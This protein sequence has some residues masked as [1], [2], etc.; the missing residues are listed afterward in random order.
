MKLK[1]FQYQ[2]FRFAFILP[3]A[4]VVAAVWIFFAFFLDPI[5]KSA[6]VSAGQAVFGAK[7]EVGGFKTSFKSFS[8]SISNLRI[9]DK[10]N[11]FKNLADIGS[12]KFKVRFIPMLSKKFIID[13]MSVDN[14]K[15]A[16]I[17]KTSAKLPP[18][19]QKKSGTGIFSK[20]LE[21][22]QK[23]AASEFEQFS[24]VQKINEAKNLSKN[25]S[26]KGAIDFANIKAVD[27]IKKS[28][29]DMSD[30]YSNY[31]KDI[32][33]KGEDIKVEISGIETLVNKISKTNIKTLDDAADLRNNLKELLSQKEK[34]EISYKDIKTLQANLSKDVKDGS[35]TIKGFDDLIK[36]DV[37]N[38]LSQLSIPSSSQDTIRKLLG[39]TWV[40]R[41]N[42]IVYYM[43]LVRQYMPPKSVSE[44]PHEA[45]IR[46]KGRDI[47]FPV[48]SVLPKLWIGN[49]SLTANSGG[50]G[51]E[52][53]PVY[54]SGYVRNISSNQSLIG[55]PLAFEIASD[56]KK[57]LIKIN[58]VFDR[59]TD[60]PTD[61]ISFFADGT[62]ASML[63]IPDS[64]Y[65]PS[66]NKGKLK[67]QSNFTLKGSD[68]ISAMKLNLYSFGY[69]AATSGADATTAKYMSML[70]KGI[71]SLNANAGFSII[72]GSLKMDFSSDI[73]SIFSRRF[74]EI[75]KSE[76][77]DLENKVRAEVNK[78]I[79]EQ[80]KTDA[81]Q[82]QKYA[83]DLEKLINGDLSVLQGEIDKVNKLYK[84][85][86]AELT[87][88]AS[89]EAGK[90]V[91][92]LLKGL[93]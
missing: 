59:L 56:D 83:Q 23:T 40:N 28:Y 77:G 91:N 49:I 50:E 74:N 70:W 33:V 8:V 20:A 86:E 55:K 66:F 26:A 30:K 21:S 69:D 62:S 80:T 5:L 78:Y 18:K 10:D 3:T 85:K 87:S 29:Q 37:S 17:R 19:K 60:I 79:A 75:V 57:Q 88:Q 76:L 68:F 90:A 13:N 67:F 82:V 41:I 9:G 4:A 92:S 51:K 16:T 1:I 25:F 14:F 12:I 72:G 27:E 11:E 24:S 2:P 84:E 47:I 93:F 36:S 7:V 61:T 71:N 6:L 32:K 45:P 31:E 39:Q 43:E 48:R 44:N 22:A 64:S 58:G 35:K 65:T 63:G 52:G 53:T 38:V 54:Y 15:W 42:T 46:L 73:D 34:L 89:K 81:A